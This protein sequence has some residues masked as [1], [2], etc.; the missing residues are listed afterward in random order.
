MTKFY[1]P[2]FDPNSEEN[3][4]VTMASNSNS[5]AETAISSS[6]AFNVDNSDL[7]PKCKSSTVPAKLIDEEVV[8]FC[9]NCRVA[10]AVP[11]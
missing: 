11:E 8:M 10:L 9:T 6:S 2:L 4:Q 7:C 3:T 5:S 1:N